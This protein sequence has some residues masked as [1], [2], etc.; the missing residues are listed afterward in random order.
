[1]H[2]PSVILLDEPMSSFD[3]NVKKQ[4]AQLLKEFTQN[5]ILLFTSHND[6]DIHTIL[7][8]REITIEGGKIA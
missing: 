1:M 6:D 8:T 3:P 7:A 2:S 4:V 5:K